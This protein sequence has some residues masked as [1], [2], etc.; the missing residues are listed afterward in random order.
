[1]ALFSGRIRIMRQISTAIGA[2]L[3]ALSAM[4]SQ[5]GAM[6]FPPLSR[7]VARPGD[8]TEVYFRRGFYAAGGFY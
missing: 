6:P 4:I 5:A 2:A 8:L 7:A 3:L 1:M